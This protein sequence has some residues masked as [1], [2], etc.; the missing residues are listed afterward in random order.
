M[1]A[2]YQD[3]MRQLTSSHRHL[4]FLDDLE[5]ELPLLVLGSCLLAV[6]VIAIYL[7]AAVQ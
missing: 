1:S 2:V 3:T 4:S 6:T 7:Y 5:P